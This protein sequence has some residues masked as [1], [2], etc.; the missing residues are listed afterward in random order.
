[1]NEA[2]RHAGSKKRKKAT[3]KKAIPPLIRAL[4]DKNNL[5]ALIQFAF[6][7]TTPEALEILEYAER[8]GTR[9]FPLMQSD[10]AEFNPYYRKRDAEITHGSE[11]L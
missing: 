9:Q 4:E 8:T 5:D 3:L 11:M 10:P 2:E 6:L 1:M 7:H